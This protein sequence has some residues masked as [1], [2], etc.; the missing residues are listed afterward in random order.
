MPVSGG[1]NGVVHF[2]ADLL[3]DHT[4]SLYHAEIE[5]WNHDCRNLSFHTDELNVGTILASFHHVACLID[6]P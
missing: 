5:R 2:P 3:P 1:A 4:S 6:E